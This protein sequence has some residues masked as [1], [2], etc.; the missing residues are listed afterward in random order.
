MH[1]NRVI[2][3]PVVGIIA[4]TLP[5]CLDDMNNLS[6]IEEQA[7]KELAQEHYREEV[8][9]AKQRIRDRINQRRWWHRFIPFTIRIE[10]RPHV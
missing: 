4:A 10:R 7:R 2:D 8:E 1:R 9:A 5:G 3:M 6:D